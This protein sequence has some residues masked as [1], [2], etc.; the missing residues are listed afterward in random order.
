MRTPAFAGEEKVRAQY[1]SHAYF[2]QL[3]QP[4]KVEA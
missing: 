1:A 4:N 3:A 2:V